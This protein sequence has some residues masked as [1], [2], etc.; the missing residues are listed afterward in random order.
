MIL[1][2][3]KDE[4]KSMERT[5][6]QIGVEVLKMQESFGVITST[7]ATYCIKNLQLLGDFKPEQIQKVNET[8]K[9]ILNIT[10]IDDFYTL[11]IKPEFVIDSMELFNGLTIKF[12]EIFKDLYEKTKF[13]IKPILDSYCSKWVNK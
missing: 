12:I 6:N 2:I 4:F 3:N 11:W 13:L 5:L 10:I 7:K 9:G 8:Y 1:I